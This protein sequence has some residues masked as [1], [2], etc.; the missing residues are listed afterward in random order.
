MTFPLLHPVLSFYVCIGLPVN[1]T[2]VVC[3]GAQ[4]AV[5]SANDTGMAD[6][7]ELFGSNY[8]EVDTSSLSDVT[9]TSEFRTC[10]FSGRALYVSFLTD[11]QI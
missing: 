7:V 2:H 11:S 8:G 6:L 4:A 9:G 1:P 10:R 5:S 3:S